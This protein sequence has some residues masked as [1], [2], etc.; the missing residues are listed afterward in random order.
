MVL[1]SST[2]PSGHAISPGSQS[3]SGQD[4]IQSK[5]NQKE[6]NHQQS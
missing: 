1:G 2:I 3:A 5:T 6:L 4:D